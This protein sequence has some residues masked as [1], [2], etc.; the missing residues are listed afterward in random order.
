MKKII[1]TLIFAILF[2]S[3]QKEEQNKKI[4]KKNSLKVV[5]AKDISTLDPACADGF[6]SAEVCSQIYES[7]VGMD[8]KTGRKKYILATS[9]QTFADGLIW[10]FNIRKGVKFHDGTPMDAQSV[11]FAFQRQMAGLKAI[12]EGRISSDTCGYNY[13]KA[14]FTMIKS[15]KAVNNIRSDLN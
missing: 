15:V 8:S 4:N 12:K 6:E 14:Y 2:S 9:H 5:W 13:W 11:V 3:C 1:F 7:L 10:D